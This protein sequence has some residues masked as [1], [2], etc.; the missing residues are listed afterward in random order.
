MRELI[1]LRVLLLVKLPFYRGFRGVCPGA[2]GW[3][4]PL[5]CIF[6]GSDGHFTKYKLQHSSASLLARASEHDSQRNSLPIFFRDRPRIS[7]WTQSRIASF[8][9][10]GDSSPRRPCRRSRVL[11]R[12][13]ESRPRRP[14]PKLDLGP[15]RR[16]RP[17]FCI[18]ERVEA[19][20]DSWAGGLYFRVQI[21]TCLATC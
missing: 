21:C 12:V 10:A 6:I 16:S 13:T 5:R 4:D 7:C 2:R 1:C 3:T 19:C 8:G 14:T 17:R 9:R 20:F 15:F 11:P 18:R